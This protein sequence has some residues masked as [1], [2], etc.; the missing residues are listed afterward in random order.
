MK[1]LAKGIPVDSHRNEAL[2]SGS[3][4][5]AGVGG[6]AGQRRQAGLPDGEACAD[7]DDDEDDDTRGDGGLSPVLSATN[8]TPT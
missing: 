5:L 4:A 7:E 1:N 3:V 6:D 8:L 2:D